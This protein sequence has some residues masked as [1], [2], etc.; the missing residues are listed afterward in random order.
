MRWFPPKWA[1]RAEPM[2]PVDPVRRICMAAP[3]LEC[4]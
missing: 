1:A 2:S 3:G 4:F